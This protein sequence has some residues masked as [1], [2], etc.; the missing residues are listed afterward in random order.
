M[1]KQKKQ[2]VES[3]HELKEVKTLAVVAML[4]AVAVVLG[5]YSLQ[6]TEYIKIGF[7]FIADELTGMMF[8]P[9]VGGLMGGITDLVKY[10]VSPTGPFFPG[11]TASS[12]VSGVIY[13]MVLYK[14]PLTIRR[15]ILANGLVTLIVN[16]CMNTYWL[17]LLYGHGFLAI[18]PA[19]LIKEIIMLP[20]SAILFYTVA[21]V[22]SK[23]Q[24]FVGLRSK[25]N[26]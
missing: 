8:G 10:V 24:V 14:K 20:I 18:L 5:F 26:G 23:A 17:T 12:I 2:W 25:A 11:F 13:G 16:V 6:L 4:A 21:K 9:V 19:R 1:K 15:V 7:A 3:L 22:L